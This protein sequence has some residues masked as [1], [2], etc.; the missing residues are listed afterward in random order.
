MPKNDAAHHARDIHD[1]FDQPQSWPNTGRSARQIVLSSNYLL[2]IPAA[3]AREE[4]A[5]FKAEGVRL[6]VFL[7][8]LPVDKKICGDG[9]EGLAWPGE[10]ALYASKLKM[11]GLD[12]ASFTFDLP[13][14]DGHYLRADRGHVVCNLSIAETAQHLASAVRAIRAYYPKADLFDAEVPTGM[15][16]A[17]WIAGV[18]EWLDDFQQAAGEPFRGLIMDAWWAFRWQDTVRQT[19]ALLH[20]RGIEAGMFID[21]S[22]GANMPA[23]EWLDGAKRHACAVR[24]TGAPLD[25]LVVANWS[26]PEVPNGPQSD[27][28]TLTGL[29][30]WLAHR[31]ACPP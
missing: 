25:I 16:T 8:V 1:I 29:A 13:L 23:Q 14:A 6:N 28:Q 5:R 31:G 20:A 30:D 21:E 7:A 4:A 24:A 18:S 3:T 26:A 22:E 27:P 10:A 11:L 9:V 12:V 17:Q 2:Q 19:T 15:P